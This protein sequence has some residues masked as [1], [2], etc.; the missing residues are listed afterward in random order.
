MTRYRIVQVDKH[1]YTHYEV[2]RR[3]WFGW[4]TESYWGYEFHWVR[5]FKT[6]EE[7]VDYIRSQDKP[8]RT[9]V[10]QG[11]SGEPTREMV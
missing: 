10:A 2:E 8:V 6:K 11:G 7:A 9:V 1:N 5:V 4:S 3:G